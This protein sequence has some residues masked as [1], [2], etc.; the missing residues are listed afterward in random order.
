MR[1]TGVHCLLDC[2]GCPRDVL[3]DVAG[4]ETL[5]RR[6]ADEAGATVL[7]VTS[8]AFSP[9][10]VTVLA[11]LAESHLSIHT[12]PEQGYAAAD[13]FTCGMHFQ[14]QRACEC[15][16]AGLQAAG[17]TLRVVHRSNDGNCGE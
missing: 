17:H 6:A 7:E 13:C 10:G 1:I 2:Y 11:L 4:L 9:S 16:L 5:V 15:L 12:W 14:P 8:R 3:D